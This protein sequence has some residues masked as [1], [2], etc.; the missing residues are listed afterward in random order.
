MTQLAPHDRASLDALR[1][2]CCEH[3]AV[4]GSPALTVDL[5]GLGKVVVVARNATGWWTS[6]YR[7]AEPTG[8]SRQRLTALWRAK[9]GDR[10]K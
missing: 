2:F 5:W 6:L 8:L 1:E 9:Y 10:S 7:L 3:D 4:P